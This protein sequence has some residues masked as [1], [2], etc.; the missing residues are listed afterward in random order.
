MADHYDLG[1]EGENAAVAFLIK[2]GFD[3]RH[4]NFRF[5][6][7]EI[8]IVAENNDWLI[9]VEVKTRSRAT[10][11]RPEEFISKAKQ[12]HLIRAANHYVELYPNPK[13]IRFDIISILLSPEFELNHIP[14]AFY[15]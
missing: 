3:I 11:G 5:A 1:I 14:E 15:P 6:R 10:Y 2:S 13:D 7:A 9:M 4:R 12:K 8:D